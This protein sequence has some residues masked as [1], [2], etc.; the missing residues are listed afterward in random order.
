[1]PAISVY[2]LGIW[3]NGNQTVS[4]PCSKK[5]TTVE[6]RYKEQRTTVEHGYNNRMQG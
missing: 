2:S 4:I 3:K 6:H 1:M 5:W